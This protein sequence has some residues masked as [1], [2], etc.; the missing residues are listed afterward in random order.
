VSNIFIA[1]RPPEAAQSGRTP[2]DMAATSNVIRTERRD[3]MT[4]FFGPLIG[5][6]GPTC[7]QPHRRSCVSAVLVGDRPGRFGTLRLLRRGRLTL[8]LLLGIL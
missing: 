8:H 4:S 2:L 3:I 1:L 5:R 6:A 7:P